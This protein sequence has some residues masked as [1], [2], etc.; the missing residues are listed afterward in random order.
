MNKLKF[1]LKEGFIDSVREFL[2][3]PSRDSARK[4]RE[5]C[6]R[7][8]DYL[9]F[10]SRAKNSPFIICP[11]LAMRYKWDYHT[12]TN[13][14]DVVCATCPLYAVDD[15]RGKK[16]YGYSPGAGGLCAAYHFIK[17][18]RIASQTMYALI[19]LSAIEGD[20]KSFGEFSIDEKAMEAFRSF[21]PK[22]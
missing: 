8:K 1:V 10:G 7:G 22:F 6:Y 3:A 2:K 4:A 15:K 9:A 18:T 5:I 12:K 21:S 19:I 16:K 13:S 11:A 20:P 17:R 14:T